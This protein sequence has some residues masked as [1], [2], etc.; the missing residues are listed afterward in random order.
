MTIWERIAEAIAAL[1]AGESLTAVL[2]K[3]RHAA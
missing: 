3:L 2:E 1:R